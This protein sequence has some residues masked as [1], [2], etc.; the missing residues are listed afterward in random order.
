M[1]MA[2]TNI[3]VHRRV[4]RRVFPAVML[5][6]VLIGLLGLFTVRNG[7]VNNV[8]AAHRILLADIIGQVEAQFEQTEDSLV[9][10]AQADVLDVNADFMRATSNLGVRNAILALFLD[11][12]REH[13]DRYV[14]LRLVAANGNVRLHVSNGAQ[15][16]AITANDLEPLPAE[17]F[18]DALGLAEGQ[19]VLTSPQSLR[20][21]A[22]FSSDNFLFVTP[23]DSVEGNEGNIGVLLLEVATTE[24]LG[25]AYDTVRSDLKGLDGRRILVVNDQNLPLVD[26]SIMDL[27]ALFAADNQSSN[28]ASLATFLSNHPG[29]LIAQSNSGLVISAQT[30]NFGNENLSTAWAD[31][32]VALDLPWRVVLIDSA[33]RLFGES[34]ILSLTVFVISLLVGLGISALGTVVLRQ[35][36]APLEQATELARQLAADNTSSA[37]SVSAATDD[38]LTQ[39][40][41][42]LSGRIQTL[43]SEI[44]AERKRLRSNLAVAARVSREAS[45]QAD[46]DTLLTRVITLI[47][48]EP[49]FHHAQIFLMDDINEHAIL[50]YSHGPLGRELLEHGFKITVRSATV[51]GGVLVER[52]LQVDN[53]IVPP[54]DNRDLNLLLPNTRSR[55]VLPLFSGDTPLGVLDIQST[56]T[57]A[58][59]EEE[60]QAFELLADQVSIGISNI[61]LL[62][63]SEA[64]V[65]EIDALNR[66]FTRDAWDGIEERLD[67]EQAYHYDLRDVQPGSTERDAAALSVPITIRGEVVGALDVATPEA[68]DFTQDEQLVLQAIT[69]RVALAIDRAR[70]FEETQLSLNETSVLY[71]LSSRINEATEL[72]E[73][74][75]AL[76]ASVLQGA[77]SGQII[78]FDDTTDE[79]AT[80]WMTITAD[81][82]V[83][84][85]DQIQGELVGIRLQIGESGFLSRLSGDAVTTVSD[86][87]NVADLDKEFHYILQSLYARALVII[88]LTIRGR[89][90]GLIAV[91]FRDIRRFTE[92]DRRLYTAV[93]DQAGVA[94][95]NSLLLRQTAATLDLR[96]RMYGASRSIN[97]SQRVEDLVN[98]L[99]TT[100]DNPNLNFAMSLL[101][102]EHNSA[103]WPQT[104]RLLV[105]SENGQL[106]PLN[107]SIPLMVTPESP[108][109]DRQPE[110]W[111]DHDQAIDTPRSSHIRQW[112][113]AYTA[114][115]PLFSLDNPIALLYL[116]ADDTYEMGADDYEFYISLTGQMSTALQNQR[117]L[118]QTE[119]AL[120]DVSRLYAASREITGAPDLRMVYRTA[121]E[122]L[123][124]AS[125][126]TAQIMFLLAVPERK[127]DAPFLEY[128]YIWDG[129]TGDTTSFDQQIARADV[130]YIHLVDPEGAVLIG[131]VES[132]LT[133][134]PK[135]VS[136]LAASNIRSLIVSPLQFRQKWFGMLVCTSHQADAYDDPYRQ[137]VQTVGDQVAIAVENYDLIATA[138]EER[139]TLSSILET[140]PSG[141]LVLDAKTYLPLTT[142][143]QIEQLLGQAVSTTEPFSAA[144]YNLYRTGTQL[145]YNDDEL[146]IFITGQSGDLAFADDLVAVHADGSQVD[147]LLN[148]APIHDENGDIEM[149]VA[150]FE[151]ISS[152]RGLENALQDNLRETIALYEATRALAEA[153]EVD[154]VLDVIIVQ[155]AMIEPHDAAVVVFDDAT[156]EQ[157]VAR[158]LLLPPEEFVLPPGAFDYNQSVMIDDVTQHSAISADEATDLAARGLRAIGTMPLRA[159]ARELPIAWLVMTYSEPHPFAPEEERYLTTLGDS[160]ATALDNRYL[161]QST[162]NALQ[163]ASVLFQ[164]S[165]VLA[166]STGPQDILNSVVDHLANEDTNHVFMALLTTNSW[167]APGVQAEVVVGWNADE[168]SVDLQGVTLTPDQFPAWTILS[169]PELVTIV[170]VE[171]TP[172]LDMLE[173]AGIESLGA[174]SVVIIPLRVANRAIGAIWMGAPVPHEYSERDLRVYQSFAEQTS[175]A[176]DAAHLFQQAER[177]AGQL[178]TSAQVSQFASSILELDMLLPRLVDLIMA[179]FNYD[180]VQIFLMD[181]ED[182]F[183]ELRAS[184][185][186]AGQKLLDA[187]HKLEKGSMS[188]I[189]AVTAEARPVLALDTGTV[190]V[191]HKPNPFLPHTRSEMAL[192]LIIK[193]K[194]VGALDVQ[195]NRSNAFNDEDVSV[196]TTLAAQISVAIDNARLFEQAEH[197]AS[198]MSLLF[199]VTTAAASAET[200]ADALNHVASDLRD[201]LNA[202]TVGIYLPV[203][204]V[205]EI[206]DA[207]RMTMRA[208][209][210]A[211]FDQPLSEILEIPVGS[212]DS[213]IG[214][215]ADIGRP[216]IINRVPDEPDY[217]PLS[218]EAQ[219]AVVVPLLTGNEIIGLI[220]MENSRS[221]AYSHE[222]L[223]L[224]QTMGGT[225][226]ALIQNQQLLEQL[227]ETNTQLRE[228][229]RIKSE[230]LANMSHELRTPLN[231]IIGFSRVILKGIDGPLTEM[232]EQDLTTIYN[233]GQHLLNLIN[234]ILDQAKIAAGKMEI[235]PEYFDIKAVVDGVRSIGIGLV[236][237]NPI[238]IKVDI[239]SG[240]PQVYGDEFRTRQVLLNLLSNAAKFTLEGAITLSVYRTQHGTTDEDMVRVDVKDTGIGIADADIPLLFQAF[241]QVDSSLTRTAGGTGLGLPISK[242]LIEMQGGEMLVE[243]EVNEGSTFSITIPIE[244]PAGGVPVNT[245]GD[246]GQPV[247]EH[248][249][250]T[251]HNGTNVTSADEETIE[252]DDDSKRTNTVPA[253]MTTKRQVLV[254]EDNAERVD[255]FRRAIQREGFDVFAASIPLEA[256][257][258][259]SGL[260]PSV[261]ILDVNFASGGGWDIL[262]KIKDRD[263][264]FDIPV[265]VVTLSDEKD[266]ALAMGA[267]AFL[268]H[269]I[270]PEELVD[271]VLAAEKDANTDRILII[272]DQPESARLLEQVL[273]EHGQYRVFSAHNGSEGVSLVARRRPDLVLLDLRMPEMDGFAVLQELRSNPETAAIPV[274]VVTGDTLNMD[275]QSQ[276]SGVDVTYKTDITLEDCKTF[277][278]DVQSRLTRN[279]D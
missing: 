279:G 49:Q 113:H 222:T 135:L 275:E 228:L 252:I 241:R 218:G 93:I 35:A 110:I 7:T 240:I 16:A 36:L 66:E 124:S 80:T 165:R 220:T 187:Q 103:G 219:S 1:T 161:F 107:I 147:L 41:T 217:L 197:R 73:I 9:S 58:F 237:D 48:A 268:Q 109:R 86:I 233:S 15:G 153:D 260:R 42:K 271:N 160:A 95:D 8:Q 181:R 108:L 162:E 27:G 99:L 212:T 133:E 46:L 79:T 148:A 182:R 83:G 173:Q 43:G 53:Q 157:Q 270:I 272:D 251:G 4:A 90:R 146:P 200:L 269:P 154:D 144:Y 47:C 174:Q 25:A 254:I 209:A 194:V 256:E 223:T 210:I 114:I 213:I 6:F 62:Q 196:L 215:A 205:D 141:V 152:L 136:E 132:N 170:D 65:A 179:A 61:R 81:W 206:T 202:L 51:I 134:Q 2:A 89:W 239:E 164:A 145:H 247:A 234:D 139:E 163:E 248:T 225:L 71:D 231:S 56:E 20:A 33:V 122:H 44:E 249:N 104:E 29:D 235:K 14:S 192:P 204:Y 246:E 74:V 31:L 169:S 105:R 60:L 17:L 143:G 259:A 166:D 67:I 64:R 129:N 230:F 155:M 102:G 13:P 208:E 238:D 178:Q 159:R 184:T 258:M 232:Q 68:G 88:P 70:L 32:R 10:L 140:M 245:E 244:P 186:E 40:I 72:K 91:Q 189:G 176:L 57:D 125:L 106:L 253:V 118:V 172:D 21:I 193:G 98:A 52:Q 75:A 28:A 76:T 183:A 97:A 59:L 242:S 150:A 23:L 201:S 214:M 185:G 55:L 236:K 227:Q 63:Q 191:V 115:F 273:D 123:S 177:R 229:D 180:H 171:N 131:N 92:Q 5:A 77:S 24:L 224:L 18:E 82:S 84:P 188:V 69:D 255:Q 274:L 265:V 190:D 221:Y 175:L 151:N 158:T 100:T 38:Q 130:P 12:M 266:R 101:E 3:P 138:E 30:I 199:A 243:T 87:D 50:A 121:A 11:W 39:S 137:F 45:V 149:I 207:Q 267:F 226:T 126:A 168:N 263:D 120:Q 78:E 111:R 37:P 22:D 195:S 94:I 128:G 112:G 276:L 211:G 117:L 96:E 216:R 262:Q 142:N 119:A 167:D 261:I 277:I 250:G 278:S 26:S 85:R 116:L 198:D 156:L 34:N 127:I 257:A 19:L 203:I 264:T 54:S